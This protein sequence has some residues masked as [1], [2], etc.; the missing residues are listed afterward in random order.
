MQTVTATSGEI[1]DLEDVKR[2][3]RIP[4]D[5]HDEDAEISSML[6]A[7]RVNAEAISRRTLRPS[8]T[9]VDVLCEWFNRYVFRNPPLHTTPAIAV[10]YYD[11]DNVLQTVDSSDYFAVPEVSTGDEND[12]VSFIE[13]NTNFTHPQL[14]DRRP[15]PIQITYTTGYVTQDAI[16]EVAK[17]AVKL[18]VWDQYYKETDGQAPAKQMLGSIAFGFYA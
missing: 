18:L 11:T 9:R 17:Q 13:F 2:F 10:K 3:L 4:D 7:A 16:P 1:L 5:V 8:V 6:T 15:D 14:Y 12:G